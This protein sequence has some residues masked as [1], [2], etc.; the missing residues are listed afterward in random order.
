MSSLI[1]PRHTSDFL[2]VESQ[3]QTRKKGGGGL[4]AGRAARPWGAHEVDIG[5]LGFVFSS[6]TSFNW[7]QYAQIRD[8]S[9]LDLLGFQMAPW[10]GFSVWPPTARKFI[11]KV[12]AAD[13]PWPLRRARS[14]QPIVLCWSFRC[15]ELD[16]ARAAE[17]PLTRGR[18]ST[19]LFLLAFLPGVFVTPHDWTPETCDAGSLGHRSWLHEYD[20]DLRRAGS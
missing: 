9:A 3:I 16:L 11:S 1:G 15:A 20:T 2:G 4:G 14:T 12:R 10:R 8:K 18:G 13:L 7:F 19:M 6:Y 5:A 17:S